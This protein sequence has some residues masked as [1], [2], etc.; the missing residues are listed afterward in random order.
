MLSRT[1]CALH[2]TS[3]E[4]RAASLARVPIGE[5]RIIRNGVEVPSRLP[6]RRWTPDGTLR[7]LFLGR[8]D[9]KKGIENLLHGLAQLRDPKITLEIC[10]TGE[11]AYVRSLVQLSG[12][13]KLTE[14]VLFRGH[15]VGEEKAAAFARSDLCV[16]PS[17]NENFCMVV[18][19]SLAH[20]VPAIASTGT[21][22]EELQARHCGLWI[23]NAPASLAVGI[24]RMRQLPL[25]DM[26][27][28]GRLWMQQEFGWDSVAKEMYE[29]Y[30]S[31]MDATR[32]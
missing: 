13:L 14:R 5:A 25:A 9:P 8:L 2:V 28:R 30:R 4:E 17:H 29:L 6:E 7:I 22:W 16:A 12:E 11:S 23:D 31:L 3:K 18:A 15:V 19:E 1:T 26:G 32:H 10:G 21:P 20:G 27:A 24:Q